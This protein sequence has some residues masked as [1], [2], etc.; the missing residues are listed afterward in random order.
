MG[1]P[2]RAAGM[3]VFVVTVPLPRASSLGAWLQRAAWLVQMCPSPPDGHLRGS[4]VAAARRQDHSGL[5]AVCTIT[6]A[7]NC[8]GVARRVLV[9]ARGCWAAVGAVC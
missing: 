6:A 9:A 1:K 5:Q 4:T 7:L 2:A 3:H 8:S